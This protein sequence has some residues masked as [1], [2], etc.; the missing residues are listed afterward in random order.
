LLVAVRDYFDLLGGPR[1]AGA[2]EIRRAR[3]RRRAAHPDISD[4]DTVL[5]A[6]TPDAASEPLER[7]LADAAVDFLQ[8][9]P[10]IERMRVGFFAP[11]RPPAWSVFSKPDGS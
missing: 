10:I 6:G 5:G 9:A 2:P 1:H 7:D 4:D 3:T 11:A 8:M